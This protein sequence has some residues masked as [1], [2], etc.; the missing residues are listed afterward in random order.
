MELLRFL[1]RISRR[2]VV[3][4]VLLGVLSGASSTVLLAL[5]NRKLSGGAA[6]PPELLWWFIGFCVLVPVARFSSEMILLRL[7]M[8]ALYKL[9]V[10]MCRQILAAPMRHLEQLG[11]P[12]RRVDAAD[13]HERHGVRDRGDVLGESAGSPPTR[14]AA[15]SPS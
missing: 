12:D 5:L 15:C 7:G 14:W 13:R 8:G 4:A 6:A 3:A 2:T 11:A 10:R 9:R 1:L